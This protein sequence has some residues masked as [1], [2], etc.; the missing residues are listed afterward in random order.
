VPPTAVDKDILCKGAAAGDGLRL[1]DVERASPLP[2]VDGAL[3][4]EEAAVEDGSPSIGE[5]GTRTTERRRRPAPANPPVAGT[6]IPDAEAAA[7][8]S[9]AGAFAVV[10]AP[11]RVTIAAARDIG[12]G[13][14]AGV[15]PPVVAE[16]TL[17]PANK[18]CGAASARLMCVNI[19]R[20]S[21]SS[22]SS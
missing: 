18:L 19:K 11:A 4:D 21:N 17:P 15:V 8:L 2:V 7:L 22:L 3:V 6:V 14:G 1:R 5:P 12:I 13:V 10:A 16:L 9:L 20:I